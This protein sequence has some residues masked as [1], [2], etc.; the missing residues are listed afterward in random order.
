M[1]EIYTQNSATFIQTSDT[2]FANTKT[3]IL[4]TM[5]AGLYINVYQIQHDERTCLLSCGSKFKSPIRCDRRVDEDD[6]KKMRRKR[7]YNNF[8]LKGENAIICYN[9]NGIMTRARSRYMIG[10]S[11]DTHGQSPVITVKV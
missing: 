10:Q 3:N 5:Y 2:R 4:H 6:G 9:E 8:N 11:R 1:Y 7:K